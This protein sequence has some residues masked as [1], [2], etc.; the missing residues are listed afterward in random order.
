MSPA[1]QSRPRPILT[2]HPLRFGVWAPYR[3]QWVIGEHDHL[4]A[5][6]DFN[7]EVI[8]SAERAGFDTVLIAQ[9]T[10]NPIDIS[11]EILEAWTAAAAAAAVTD[12]IEI[13]AA[14]KPRLY[15]PAVLA[16]MALG[17][18]DISHGR[19]AINFVNA[20]F[21]PELIRSGIGFPEHDER[22][23]Y[24]SEWL[25]I[26]KSLMAGE[27][28]TVDGQNFQLDRFSLSPKSRYRD[29]P[30]IYAGGESEAGTKLVDELADHW[31][32]NGRPLE[33][34]VPLVDS[35]LARR[36]PNRPPLGIGVT[37]FVL[38]R[39]TDEEAEAEV[40]RL[41]AIQEPFFASRREQMK[42]NIDEKAEALKVGFKY[43]GKPMIGANG[44]TLPGFVGSY[45]TVARRLAE[46]HGIGISTF[47]LSFFPLIAEQERFAQHVIPRARSLVASQSLAKAS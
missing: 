30:V 5:D 47:M 45:E 40:E 12:R 37:G 13:I 4:V 19:F 35:I 18:E 24:G 6:F 14:I 26:V 7:R 38:A 25:R 34:V 17:I 42:G 3:G 1:N 20:W 22:Y 9:H 15:H 29:R 33:D 23:A 39:E 16:K 41:L 46:F 28:V 44:G 8:K 21:K 36:A 27:E 43:P 2:G 32:I 31:L 11:E 10:I